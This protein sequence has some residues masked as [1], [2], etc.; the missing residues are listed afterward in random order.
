MTIIA[1]SI[2]FIESMSYKFAPNMAVITFFIEIIEPRSLGI[3]F[4]VFII[5]SIGSLSI[6]HS[7]NFSNNTFSFYDAKPMKMFS[8]N[9]T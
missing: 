2:N 8:I 5:K 4:A 3:I 9:I 1:F 6:F 7:K